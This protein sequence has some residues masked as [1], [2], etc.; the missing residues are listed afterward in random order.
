MHQSWRYSDKLPRSEF[1]GIRYD[2]STWLNDM[3]EYD[4]ER[5]LWS[6]T[7]I[8][9]CAALHRLLPNRTRTH[10]SSMR[11]SLGTNN[12]W[13]KA[14]SKSKVYTSCIVLATKRPETSVT[15]V[16]SVTSEIRRDSSFRY[17]PT[18]RSCPSWATANDCVYLFGVIR[19]FRMQW[20]HSWK[21]K[22]KI[23]KWNFKDWI[24]T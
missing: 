2:G 9:G 19:R 21:R 6:Q 10:L 20:D 11:A 22:R 4:F 7:T 23:I 13:R 18:G 14:A 17:T 8:S 15:S 24:S 12:N 1:I 16:T 3:Y 5:R